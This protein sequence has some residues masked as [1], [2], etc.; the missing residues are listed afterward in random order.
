MSTYREQLEVLSDIRIKSGESRRID[1]PFCGGRN[2]LSISSVDGSLLWNC[3]KASCN[4]G[5]RKSVGRTASQIKDHLTKPR[6][7]YRSKRLRSRP[8]PSFLSDPSHHDKVIEYLKQNGSYE[9]YEDGLIKIRYAPADDRVLFYLPDETGA[10]GR[11]LRGA[12]PKWMVYGDTDSLFTVGTGYIAVVVEDAASAC[13]IS[14]VQNLVGCALLGTSMSIRQKDQ[15]R[16][17]E[18]VIIALDKDASQKSIQMQKKL[19]GLTKAE[20]R[21]LNDDPKHLTPDQ[22]RSIMLP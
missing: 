16:K 2:T 22:I 20:L 19:T 12:K 3:Y 17:Y 9:A 11:S 8:I 15:L 5:G 21:F 14:R 10:V 13:G 1:C 4:A 18:R 6:E 7:F